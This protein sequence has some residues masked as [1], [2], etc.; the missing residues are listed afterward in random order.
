MKKIAIIGGGASGLMVANY[1]SR[2]KVD[3]KI[4][5]FERNKGL[6]RKVLASGNGKCNFM[7]YKALPFDYNNYDFIKK[8]FSNY[9]VDTILNYFQTLGLMFKFDSEGRMYPISDSSETILNLL[10]AD[11]KN[12]EI[13]LNETVIDLKNK[14]DKLILNNNEVFDYVVIASG[15]NASIDLKKT[16]STYE[17]LK[18]LNLKFKNPLPG[19]VGFKVKNNIKELS[20]FRTKAMVNLYMEDNIVKREFGEVIFKDDG[21]SGICVMDLSRYFEKGLEFSIGL[22]MLQA[23]TELVES[24]TLRKK[25]NPDPNYYLAGAFH[26]KMI[27]Y[28][29]KQGITDIEK[30]ADLMQNFRLEI[31]DVYGMEFAQIAL[32]GISVDEIDDKFSLIKYPNIMVSGEVLDIDGKCGGYNL[33]FAFL[34]GY[35]VAKALEEKINEISDM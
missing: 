11:L 27:K 30:A 33:L 5:I 4:T 8:I 20:G 24:M 21:I 35:I 14:E 13:R 15:S 28:L 34:S 16:K 6:G 23:K 32:G 3:A 25:Q 1:L 18:N 22:N 7:N 2:N 9:P 10:T 31:E 29:I 26:P 12:I 17:Y 19:L